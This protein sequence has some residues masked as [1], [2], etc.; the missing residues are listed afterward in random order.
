MNDDQVLHALHFDDAYEVKT[1]L[2]DGAGGL[3]EL[4]FLDGAGPFV[5]KKIPEKMVRRGVWSALSE[6]KCRRL[7]HVVATYELPDMFVVVYDYVP[8]ETLE[9]LVAA[10]GC[11][12]PDEAIKLTCEVCEAAGALHAY[13]IVHR[14]ITPANVI[15]AA[16]GAHLVD[17]GIARLR[18]DGVSK[19]TSKLGTWGFASPEQFGF[20]QTDARSDVY[21]IGRLLGY[22][23]TGVRPDDEA[24]EKALDEQEKVPPEYRAVI[25]RACLFEPSSRYQSAES[26]AQALQAAAGGG[27]VVA[28]V[29]SSSTSAATVPVAP[30]APVASAVSAASAALSNTSAPTAS[31]APIAPSASTVSAVPNG[32]SATSLRPGGEEPARP[33]SRDKKAHE[34]EFLDGEQISKVECAPKS[35]RTLTGERVPKSERKRKNSRPVLI[36]CAVLVCGLVAYFGASAFLENAASNNATTATSAASQSVLSDQD[37]ASD[38]DI[39]SV[40]NNDGASAADTND[41]AESSVTSL[42]E[43]RSS[44][45]IAAPD[46]G[47]SVLESGW[48]CNPNGYVTYAYALR[49]D[50]D[51]DTILFPQ[52]TV[53]GKSA[54]GTILFSQ[55]DGMMGLGPGETQYCCSIADGGTIPAVV[56]FTPMKPSSYNVVSTGKGGSFTVSKLAVSKSQLGGSKVTGEVRVD[57]LSTLQYSGDQI[58]LVAILRDSDGKLISGDV[59]FITSP[60]QGQ[61]SAFSVE[62][63]SNVN[64]DSVEVYASSW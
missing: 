45:N 35:E 58:R 50:S 26:L 61:S 9:S 43:G 20:A 56:E 40:G 44:L 23:L 60:G 19:D 64:F 62:L 42:D 34:V 22:M 21:S 7:P 1:V 51:T 6:C 63:S 30:L 36:A 29:A 31:A 59:G 38:F 57:E 54:D 17:L 28:G 16:D 3:T 5:R 52:V 14:D 49:N 11:I 33:V 53:T 13:S 41:F 10:H 47:L 39:S 27:E 32:T 55:E 4:V 37:T 48:S 2:A 12:A 18:V 24:Y 25:D 46:T 8:G 15:V